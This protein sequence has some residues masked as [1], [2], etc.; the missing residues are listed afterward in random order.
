ML[1]IEKG[2]IFRYLDLVKR[3]LQLMRNNFVEKK[4]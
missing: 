4:L 1:L 2:Q 3:K